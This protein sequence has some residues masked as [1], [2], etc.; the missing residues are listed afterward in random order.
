MT[1]RLSGRVVLLT[2]ATGGIGTA[3]ARRLADDGALVVVTDV[4]DSR[5]QEL[6]AQLDGAVGLALDVSDEDAWAA[7]VRA[8]DAEFGRLTALV[9]NAGIARSTTV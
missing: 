1:G 3:T 9:N 8:V 5:C 2:G 4:D 6:A 7:A